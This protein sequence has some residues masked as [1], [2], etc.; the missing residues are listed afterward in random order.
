[1]SRLD[2]WLAEHGLAESREKAQALV[3]A[4]AVVAEALPAEVVHEHPRAAVDGRRA[5]RLQRRLAALQI[6]EA[7]RLYAAAHNGNLP[8]TL[9]D[10]RILIH[11]EHLMAQGRQFQ[12]QAF[13][14][15]Y[16]M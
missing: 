13:T 6:V 12:G 10:I 7:I 5:P 2:V 16:C 3:M 4:G 8:D 1:M 9:D 14:Y 15:R 11:P